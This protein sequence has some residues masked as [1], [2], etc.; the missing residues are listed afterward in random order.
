MLAAGA[1]SILPPWART[2][3]SLPSLP[4]TDRVIARPLARAALR[5]IRWALSGAEV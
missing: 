4:A 1:V 3:L 2:A 5:T